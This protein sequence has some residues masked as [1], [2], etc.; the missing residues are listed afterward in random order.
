MTHFALRKPRVGLLPMYI[1]LYDRTHP[2]ARGGFTGFIRDVA[3]RLEAEGV[4]VVQS[5][6]CCVD[7]EFRS[8]VALFEKESVDAVVTL[9]L[10]YSPSEEALPALASTSLPLLMLDT[11]MD[12]SY[13]RNVEPSRLMYNHGVHGVQ[14]LASLFRRHGRRYEIVAGH[15]EHSRVIRRAAD[16]IRAFVAA[17]EFMN[18][19]VLR[20]GERFAGMGDFHVAPGVLGKTFGITVAQ[21]TVQELAP[22]IAAVT[23]SAVRDEMNENAALFDVQLPEDTHRA[24]VHA[25]L[26]LRGFIDETRMD[27]VSVNFLAATEAFPMP[28]LEVSKA[29]SRGVGYAG[30]GDV[31]TAALVGA[32]IRAYGE[33][34]F[35]E[36]FCPDW[37]GNALFLSHMG[38]IN[39]AVAAAKPV[40]LEKEFPYADAPAPAYI[41]CSIKPGRA[42]LA[43]LAPGP[44]DAFRLI[45]SRVDVL[46][47]TE[48]EDLKQSVRAWVEPPVPVADFLEAYSLLGG[49]HH[50]ALVVGE[51][52][53]SLAV[54]ARR[55]GMDFRVIE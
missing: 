50:S 26:A 7:A 52:L 24:S 32:F 42:V 36:I 38:E 10:A 49:T 28:F 29:M 48:R 33:A 14:D 41:A 4:G 25:G 23:E 11:T 16:I 21:V 54:F 35:T 1:S 3:A 2:S 19:R 46:D 39:P 43:N 44:D 20:V 37:Q 30:E 31:L 22:Y 53:E 51:R 15:L 45:A 55:A 17:D 18:S 5:G 27:A 6:I 8:A 47:D 34:T 12:Y 40:L 13:G 9:H